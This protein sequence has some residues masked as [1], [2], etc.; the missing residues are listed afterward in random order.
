ME[1]DGVFFPC[2]C[3]FK[4]HFCSLL[5]WEN[6]T[7]SFLPHAVNS[8]LLA[9]V[10]DLYSRPNSFSSNNNFPPGIP[11]RKRGKAGEKWN[12]LVCLAQQT[13]LLFYVPIWNCPMLLKTG[14]R[15]CSE[16]KMQTLFCCSNVMAT[17]NG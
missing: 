17:N 13:V 14:R 5:I 16:M 10:R 11:W 8:G 9:W 4:S 2:L 1:R 7:V 12:A 3:S 15:Y 6:S